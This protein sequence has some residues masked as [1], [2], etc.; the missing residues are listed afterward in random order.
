MKQKEIKHHQMRHGEVEI[1]LA[2]SI[3]ASFAQTSAL[4]IRTA[5]KHSCE[6]AT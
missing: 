4:L 3:E 1:D 2:G 6:V 5:L